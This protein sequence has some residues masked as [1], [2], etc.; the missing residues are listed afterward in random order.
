VDEGSLRDYLAKRLAACRLPVRFLPIT[1]LPRN[2][3][4]KF[5]RAQLRQRATSLLDHAETIL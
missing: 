4:G 1:R 5:D 3:T 2:S